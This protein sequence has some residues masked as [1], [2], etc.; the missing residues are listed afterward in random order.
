MCGRRLVLEGGQSPGQRGRLEL[1]RLLGDQR[2]EHPQLLG[3]ERVAL[4]QPD[5]QQP[6]RAARVEPGHRL[7]GALGIVGA[8]SPRDLPGERV[9]LEE[10][11]RDKCRVGVTQ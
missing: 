9:P 5:R 4:A 10:P 1:R 8:G 3:V 2:R 11:D 6:L 7:E